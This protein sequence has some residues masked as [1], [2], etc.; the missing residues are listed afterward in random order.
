MGKIARKLRSQ[1]TRVI[2]KKHEARPS[3]CTMTEEARL[4]VA[5]LNIGQR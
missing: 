5:S 3:P 1:N 4:V 2:R